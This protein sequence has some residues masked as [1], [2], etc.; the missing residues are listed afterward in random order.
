M[1]KLFQSIF[2]AGGD[3][4]DR[5]PAALRAAALDRALEAT[6][7]RIRAVSGHRAR[8]EPAILHAIGH[9]VGLVDALP[10]AIEAS[11]K[12][13]GTDDRLAA[14]FASADRMAEV[15]GADR[16]LIEF[17]ASPAGD[18]T[19]PVLALLL[20]E[21]SEKKVLG[22]ALQGDQVQH[23]VAQV[24]VSFDR[25]RLL[26]PS[27]TDEELRRLLKRRAFDHLLTMALARITEVA[28]ER[29]SLEQSQ[30]LLRA[31]L[32]ALQSARLGFEREQGNDTPDAAS[33]E[34]RLA[35]IELN[36]AAVGAGSTA[37]PRHLDILVETLSRAEVQTWVEPVSVVMD[38]LGI[39]QA[40]PG[41]PVIE[42]KLQELRNYAGQSAVLLPVAIPRGEI[43]Q[44][45]VMAQIR[46][47]LW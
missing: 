36:L 24:Q 23:E 40:V 1:F 26:D 29:E 17:L 5:Y 3:A 43:R 4:G 39:K 9:V 28:S 20:V 18:G 8:L 30:S 32:R 31:K 7:P 21:R 46:R 42:L 41:G 45:D 15:F 27:A 14:F 38:R 13:C 22:M 6:D 47:E 11:R 25:H 37:L 35:E 19:E 12:A 34:S 44:R 33:I 2:G 16:A 10:P